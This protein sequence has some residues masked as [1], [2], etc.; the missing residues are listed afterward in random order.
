MIYIVQQ[1]VGAAHTPPSR[2]NKP[3]AVPCE[4]PPTYY[5]RHG[6]GDS[7]YHINGRCNGRYIYPLSSELLLFGSLPYVGKA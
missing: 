2:R 1:P 5:R 6:T 4:R 7:D 3:P